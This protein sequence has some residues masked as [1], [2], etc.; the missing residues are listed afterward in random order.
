MEHESELR[1]KNDM[2]RIEAEAKARAKTDRENKDIILEKIR[3]EAAERRKTLL[4]SI[5]SVI[6][7]FYFFYSEE[8]SRKL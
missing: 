8:G 5:Q 7:S 4:D 1:H 3:V 2:L 6:A